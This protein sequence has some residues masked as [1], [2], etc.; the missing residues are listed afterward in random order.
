MG[1]TEKKSLM[2]CLGEFTGYIAKG[3]RTKVDQ[4]TTEEVSRVVEETHENGVTLR[5]T[6]IEEVEYRDADPMP[7]KDQPSCS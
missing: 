4:P 7:G 2:R 5:R 1:D 3:L 6:V